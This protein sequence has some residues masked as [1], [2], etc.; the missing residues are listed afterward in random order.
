MQ[1]TDSK[2]TIFIV[3]KHPVFRL[4][5]QWCIASESN[6]E[7]IGEATDGVEAYSKIVLLEPEVVILGVGMSEIDVVEL[8]NKISFLEKRPKIILVADD[9]KSIDLGFIFESKVNG[10]IY[11]GIY[12]ADLLLALNEVIAS[13]SVYSKALFDFP[14]NGNEA[15]MGII[16]IT[17]SQKDIIARSLKNKYM[18]GNKFEVNSLLLDVIY[19]FH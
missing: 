10:L 18:N 8:T 13:N 7:V 11:K 14:R 9:E 3:D 4:G 19:G 6:F 17:D 15:G 5:L 12:T 1:F 16:S 2:H